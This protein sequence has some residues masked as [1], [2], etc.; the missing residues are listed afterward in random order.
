MSTIAAA[1]LASKV[2]V[3]LDE[4]RNTLE[5]ALLQL[6]IMRP[7][8]SDAEIID[9]LHQTFAANT[10]N[11]L[12][13]TL[14]SQ[15]AV[16]VVKAT[17]DDDD[18]SASLVSVF[19]LLSRADVL[20][21]LRDV[22]TAPVKMDIGYDLDFPEEEKGELVQEMMRRDREE[23]EQIFDG[24]LA[25]SLDLF[26]KLKTEPALERLRR[27]R[28]K[29]LAHT[30]IVYDEQKKEYRRREPKDYGLQWGDPEKVAK[31]G[32]EIVERLLGAV[33]A[34]GISTEEAQKIFADN[35]EQFWRH[36]RAGLKASGGGPDKPVRRRTLPAK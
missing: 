16:D 14:Y 33:F 20:K 2:R 31:I 1:Q 9:P 6:E 25:Q 27:A 28:N 5:H 34:T 17:L 13:W 36:L 18:G 10:L 11:A 8:I 35:A 19:A 7:L 4:A 24:G 21:E 30:D 29:I 26:T 15:A 22:R 12:N 3:L 23:A 32:C